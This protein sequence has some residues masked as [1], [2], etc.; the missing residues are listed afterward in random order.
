ML[1]MTI[2]RRFLA[3]A[4][5]LVSASSH[6]QPKNRSSPRPATV[7][8]VF[9]SDIHFDPYSDPGKVPQLIAASVSEWGQILGSPDSPTRA[10]DFTALEKS[11]NE[12]G[13]DTDDRVL[14]SALSAIHAQ[15]RGVGAAMYTGDFLA[16]A[17]ECKYR[18]LAPKPTPEQYR[19]FTIKT[20]QYVASGI[21]SALPGVPVYFTLGNNDSGCADYSLDPSSDPFLAAVGPILAESLPAADR[22]FVAADIAAAGHY[23]ALLPGPFVRTRIVSMDDLYLSG[24]YAGCPGA[25][26]APAPAAAQLEWLKH[27]LSQARAHHERVWFIS[28]IP[29]GVNIYATGRKMIVACSAASVTPFLSSDSLAASL[30]E[31]SDIIPLAVFGHTHFDEIHFLSPDDLL[32]HRAAATHTRGAGIPIKIIPP[33]SPINGDPAFIVGQVRP[34][35]AMLVDYTVFVASDKTG[36]RTTWKPSYTYSARYHKRAFDSASVRSLVQQLQAD[37]T[38]ETPEAQAYIS[39]VS[40]GIPTPLLQLAWTPYTCTL[41]H[42]TTASFTACACGAK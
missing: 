23:S 28:H 10:A 7:P 8:V 5:L 12:A 36:V 37:H 35:T 18:K 27:Q 20:V 32:P 21:R 34:S 33:I 29:P 38:L 41:S 39:S 13:I 31:N 26:P 24:R 30:A 25:Q 16:H 40:S 11:C 42:T 4:L 22:A 17:F 15:A 3:A 6:A 19:E 2:T 1:T 9:L 14:Q